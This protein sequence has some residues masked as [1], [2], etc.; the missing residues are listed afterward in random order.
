MY[1]GKKNGNL[2]PRIMKISDFVSAKSPIS[3]FRLIAEETQK[4][5]QKASEMDAQIP[6]ILILGRQI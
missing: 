6:T 5:M 3:L 1:Y 4:G 2:D